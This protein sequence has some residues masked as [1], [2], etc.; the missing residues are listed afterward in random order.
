[1]RRLMLLRHGSPV[2]FESAASDLARPLN[3]RGREE[4]ARMGA[5]L[6]E[7]HLIPDLAVVS[8]A[9]RARE[10]WDKVG[11]RLGAV[12]VRSEPQLF[13]A[14][15]DTLL[16]IVCATQAGVRTLLLIGHNPGFLDLAK[17]L[18]V[19]GDLDAQRRLMQGYPPAGLAVIDFA[20]EDWREAAP[21]VAT[22][23]R[24]VT[25]RMMGLPGD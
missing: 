5:Y 17:R 16:R 13:G 1:M 15:A 2:P 23:I 4:A 11:L 22:L 20:I 6:G 25:P 14:S 24:F 8:P 18:A 12:P 10:A 21:P 7:E 9:R 3:P 19:A